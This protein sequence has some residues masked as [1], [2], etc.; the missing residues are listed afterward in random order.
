VLAVPPDFTRLNSKAADRFCSHLPIL[1]L[2]TMVGPDGNGRLVTHG[3]SIG[4]TH[5]MFEQAAALSL[6]NLAKSG[7]PEKAQ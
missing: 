4:D 5:G 2:L 6:R 3:M 1:Y 7:Q